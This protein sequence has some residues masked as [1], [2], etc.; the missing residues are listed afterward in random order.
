MMRVFF[1]I[2]MGGMGLGQSSNFAPDAAKAS[3]AASSIYEIIDRKS[4]IDPEQQG[5][6]TLAKVEGHIEFRDVHFAYPSRPGVA[7]FQVYF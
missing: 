7:V 1:A 6:V 3:V 4:P 2:I 5:G